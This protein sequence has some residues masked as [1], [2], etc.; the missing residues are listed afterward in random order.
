VQP[1]RYTTALLNGVA[2]METLPVLTHQHYT[3]GW[4]CALSTELTAAMAM[5]DEEHSPLSQH[6]QDNNTYTLG[7]IG[8]H[9]VV[10]ASLPSGQMGNNSAATVAA[11][12]RYSFGAIRFALMVG[13]GGG[14]P[15]EEHDIRLGDVVVSNPGKHHGGLIQYDFGRT[16]AEG[17]FVRNDALNAPPTL[18]LTAVN[19]LKARHN[20][21]GHRLMHY[22]S[23][24]DTPRLKAKYTYQGAENDILFKAQYDH[25]GNNMSCDQCDR[26]M[27]VLRSDRDGIEPII[28]YGL[29]ASGN[30]VMRHGDTRERWRRESDVLCFEME[31]A[32]LM[33]NFPCL[34]IRGICDYADS[35]KNKVCQGKKSLFS[36]TTVGSVAPG[37]EASDLYQLS[38]L[39]LFWSLIIR[40]GRSMLQQRR[41]PMLKSSYLS[42]RAVK[43]RE[44]IP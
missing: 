1:H 10:M 32:G 38:L 7:R 37:P 4:I 25:I 13:I 35:H 6:P 20:L 23:V 17:R 27:V 2:N 16:V 15:S 33:T 12:M 41:P 40:Y 34:V 24:M 8:E 26:N 39:I 3:V 18:L 44:H 29:I 30:Q 43:L 21:R 9:N 31:A 14:V 42:F 36:Q 5:L 19:T 22:L 11:Q 28:H